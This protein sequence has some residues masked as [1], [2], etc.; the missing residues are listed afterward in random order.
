MGLYLFV[1]TP[2]RN[3]IREYFK[4]IHLRLLI[5]DLAVF[6]PIA[7]FIFQVRFDDKEY[8]FLYREMERLV[9]WVA[10]FGRPVLSLLFGIYRPSVLFR[11]GY[12]WMIPVGFSVTLGSAAMAVSA[13][14][15]YRTGWF[16]NFPRS[17]FV[18][19]WLIV[20]SLSLLLR[21]MFRRLKSRQPMSLPA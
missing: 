14:M 8:R 13:Y 12:R 4:T 5:L 16:E 18:I 3:W 11:A 10:F 21:L 19:D 2:L 1:D 20:L 6:I 15:G 7:L 9:F 17:V